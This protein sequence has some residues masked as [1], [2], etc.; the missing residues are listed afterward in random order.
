MKLATILVVFTFLIYGL[1][2]EPPISSSADSDLASRRESIIK[3]LTEA[4]SHS[5]SSN[6][7]YGL[8]FLKSLQPP[9][10][11]LAIVEAYRKNWSYSKAFLIWSVEEFPWSRS[12]RQLWSYLKQESP[13]KK[14]FTYHTW[15]EWLYYEAWIWVPNWLFYFLNS[16]VF[17]GFARNVINWIKQYRIAKVTKTSW[18][19]PYVSVIGGIV[20]LTALTWISFQKIYYQV[21]QE[22]GVLVEDTALKSANDEG[23]P[24]LAMLPSGT[25]VTI[26][27]QQTGWLLVSKGDSFLGWV[28]ESRVLSRKILANLGNNHE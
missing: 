8:K 7:H 14:T 5:T 2:A 18:T 25:I 4:L 22:S 16:L 24:A 13:I 10:L 19:V 27:R 12:A 20:L 23:S 3:E 9:L 15:Q 1:G 26:V 11:D 28:P 21:I 17:F 6:Q